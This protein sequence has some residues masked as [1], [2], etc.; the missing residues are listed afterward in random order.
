MID[1]LWDFRYNVGKPRSS[2]DT[3]P[4]YELRR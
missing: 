2:Y 1:D 3:V 4:D